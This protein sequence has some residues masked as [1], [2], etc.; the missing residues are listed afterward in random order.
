MKRWIFVII[1]L[2][3]T[4]GIMPS[5]D[6]NHQA[7]ASMEYNQKYGS[8]TKGIVC[9][10]RLCSDFDPCFSNEQ[11][12]K[13]TQYRQYFPTYLPDTFV[14]QCANAENSQSY[15]TY[16]KNLTR[17]T[18]YEYKGI[19][20]ETAIIM[21][22]T[23]KSFSEFYRDYSSMTYNSTG[24]IKSTVVDFKT[25]FIQGCKSCLNEITKN[26]VTNLKKLNERISSTVL[27][28]Q[29]GTE[30]KFEGFLPL[31]ELEK[32]AKSIQ[33][34]IHFEKHF[35][36]GSEITANEWKIISN[37]KQIIQKYPTDLKI[38]RDM[39][40]RMIYDNGCDFSGKY[41]FQDREV[42]TITFYLPQ[43]ECT[44]RGM[45][46]VWHLPIEVING[47]MI[48]GHATYSPIQTNTSN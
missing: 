25:Y 23:E 5:L 24:L 41:V 45:A 26:P 34:Q 38:N 9:G 7:N 14:H 6:L 2:V 43:L 42:K 20:D 46:G 39:T 15:F 29:N 27:F 37:N 21:N 16:W 28:Y 12:Q 3:F 44:F 48:L 11:I 22:V 4:S 35:S 19:V 32:M 18:L 33:N 1:I 40:Y 47:D 30:Y 17:K 10:Y 31:G 13:I 36:I 8:E